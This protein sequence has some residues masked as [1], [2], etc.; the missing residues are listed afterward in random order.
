MADWLSVVLCDLSLCSVKTGIF[1]KVST[2]VS[3]NGL[4]NVVLLRFCAVIEHINA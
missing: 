3:E 1:F 2:T 4:W